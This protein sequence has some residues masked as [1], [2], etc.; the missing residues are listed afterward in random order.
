MEALATMTALQNLNLD[1]ARGLSNDHIV[2]L[3]TLVQLTSLSMQSCG[4][5]TFPIGCS[6]LTALQH[7]FKL[8][9]LNLSNGHLTHQHV[10]Y[11]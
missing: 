9:D 10:F 4:S 5:G 7:I 8:A 6:T 3:S 11:L 2:A 1:F